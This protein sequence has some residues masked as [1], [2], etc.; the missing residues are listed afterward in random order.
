MS[1]VHEHLHLFPFDAPPT[2]LARREELLLAEPV[3]S[4]VKPPEAA[5]ITA[6]HYSPAFTEAKGPQRNVFESPTLRIERHSMTGGRQRFYHRNTGADEISYQVDGKR[7]LMTECGSVDL[8]PGEFVRLPNGVA[9][10][11]YGRQDI[12][13]LIY[14]SEPAVELQPASR[15]S[16]YLE[17]QFPE[18]TPAVVNELVSKDLAG[19]GQYLVLAP[20]DE[21]LLLGNARSDP[22]RL[23]VIQ[24]DDAQQG[25]AWV[26]RSAHVWIGRTLRDASDGRVYQRHLNADEVQYQVR[27]RRTLITQRGCLDIEPGDFVRIP[28]G[29]AFTS[30][31]HE[32][33]EY[34]V[35]AS[36]H[37]VA[38]AAES[39]KQSRKPDA[40]EVERLRAG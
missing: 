39:N 2:V 9:H 29:V 7:L 27:G 22:R 16:E 12:H 19:P 30:I 31:H 21:A 23:S 4:S 37:D 32:P 14:V 6:V 38:Q 35:L 5:P 15:A 28:H 25:L 8:V 3:A 11:N 36:R 10:D 40:A 20:A 33:S 1:I 13:L 18:W 26:Y 34:L 24:L 17:Q